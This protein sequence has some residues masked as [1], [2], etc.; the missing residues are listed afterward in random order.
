MNDMVKAER[1]RDKAFEVEKYMIGLARR[2]SGEKPL[3]RYPDPIANKNKLPVKIKNA[4]GDL[5]GKIAMEASA[6]QDVKISKAD[7]IVGGDRLDKS[8]R[9]ASKQDA[10]IDAVK[11]LRELGVT[12]QEAAEWL[13]WK[14]RQSGAS[15][16]AIN[17][18][19]NRLMSNFK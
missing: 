19:K 12:P 13:E 10:V 18:A 5:I 16:A 2:A 3:D 14:K 1:D 7:R 6:D 15:H 4:V 11:E 9:E 8:G 17:K